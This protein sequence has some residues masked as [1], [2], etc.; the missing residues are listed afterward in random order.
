MPVLL[1]DVLLFFLLGCMG[2]WNGDRD[3]Q[4][5]ELTVVCP[6]GW[7]LLAAYRHRTPASVVN[8]FRG[9]VL[10]CERDP[11]STFCCRGLS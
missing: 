5:S 10:I 9:G 4:P 6:L 7:K 2:R 11:P 1:G 8:P 3:C